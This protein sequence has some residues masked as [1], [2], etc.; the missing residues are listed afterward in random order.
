[1]MLSA[2]R[3]SAPPTLTRATP[4]LFS[5]GSGGVCAPARMLSGPFTALAS[6]LMTSASLT[7]GRNRQS[8][9]ASR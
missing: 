8:A 7:N 3:A 4:S 2:A 1:M 6:R 9:P 5:S